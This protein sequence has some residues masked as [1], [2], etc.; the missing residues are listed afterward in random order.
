MAEQT[1]IRADQIEGLPDLILE[2][3]REVLREE[4][5]PAP[6][7]MDQLRRSPAGAMIRLESKVDALEVKIDERFRGV[8]QRFEAV[9]QRFESLESKMDQRFEAVDQRLDALRGEMNQR[10]ESIEKRFTGFQWGMG[11]VFLIQVMI[12]G[13]LFFQ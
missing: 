3:V 11:L 1:T 12:F 10:F 8:D 5:K 6:E 2:K 9:D 4:V 13:K 7:D